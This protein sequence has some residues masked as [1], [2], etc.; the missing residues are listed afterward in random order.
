MK[1][2]NIVLIS[3][4]VVGSIF[5]GCYLGYLYTH[6]SAIASDPAEN[7]VETISEVPVV[8][9]PVIEKRVVGIVGNSMDPTLKDGG[10]YTEYK[11]EPKEG[12]IIGFVCYKPECSQGKSGANNPTKRLIKIRESD[13]AWWVLGDN[14]AISHDSGDYGWILPSERSDIWVIKLQ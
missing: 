2:F 8:S 12:D 5:A 11:I 7:I 10:I 3:L 14:R 13:G 9:E 6:K 4:V 1:K